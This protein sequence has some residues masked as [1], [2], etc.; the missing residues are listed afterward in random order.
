[1]PGLLREKLKVGTDECKVP[2]HFLATPPAAGAAA[3]DA[4]NPEDAA[5]ADDEAE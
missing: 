1:M 2:A 3:A 5:A 4:E